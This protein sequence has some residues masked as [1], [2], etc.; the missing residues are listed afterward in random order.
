[1]IETGGSLDISPYLKVPRVAL[2]VDVKCPSSKMQGRNRWTNIPKLRSRDILKFVIADRKDY[3]Y[4]RRI[5][6]RYRGPA[7]LV[8]QPVVG[9]RRRPVGGLGPRRLSRRSGHAPRTQGS[10]G[11]RPRSLTRPLGRA[12]S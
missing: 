11:R 10:L 1:M 2:S 6:R 5:V 3:L 4:A 12:G 8:F 9:F 7:T